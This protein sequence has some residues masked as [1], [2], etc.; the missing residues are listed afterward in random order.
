MPQNL[1]TQL[2]GDPS[3][4]SL[5]HELNAELA[6]SLGRAGHA[7]EEALARLR[8]MENSHPARDIAVA[9]AAAKVWA[10]FVQREAIG[11]RDQKQVIAHYGIPGEVLAQ[12]GARHKD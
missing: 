7:V 8:E 6:A 1:S 3:E 9:H 5:Q 4:Q 10:F 12:V 2:R 11:L